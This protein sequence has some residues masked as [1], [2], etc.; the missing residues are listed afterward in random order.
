M[1]HARTDAPADEPQAGW[2]G[3]VSSKIVVP[4]VV[5]VTGAVLTALV[6]PIITGR[7]QDHQERL[8]ARDQLAGDMTTAFASSIV[9]ARMV[10][11]GQIY[12]PTPDRAAQLFAAQSEYN[13]GLRDWSIASA[14][15]AAELGA[16]FPDDGIAADWRAYTAAVNGYYRLAAVTRDRALVIAAVRRYVGGR[17]IDWTALEREKNFRQSPPFLRAYETLGAWL[18]RRGDEL[19]ARVLT[20]SPRV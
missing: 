17:G 1:E 20:L 3:F 14:R 19:V 13:R 10:A 15:L 4:V 5:T 6:A 16:R 9:T 7:W 18:L 8:D 12:A 2:L 11:N